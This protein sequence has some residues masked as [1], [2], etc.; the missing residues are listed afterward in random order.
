MG[1]LPTVPPFKVFV[2]GTSYAG[3]STALNLLDLSKGE[4]PRLAHAPYEHHPDFS[5]V[6]VEITIADERD[7]FCKE[8]GPNQ[9]VSFGH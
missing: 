3:M 5:N 2:A 9:L 4:S 8:P 6:P 1:S 7:G